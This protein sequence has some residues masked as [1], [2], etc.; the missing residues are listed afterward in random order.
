ME[1]F[2]GGW[3]DARRALGRC[4]KSWEM[5][6]WKLRFYNESESTCCDD[7]GGKPSLSQILVFM[8]ADG[9]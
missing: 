7:L 9:V 1:T 2:H 8:L 5:V 6:H 4:Y 3:A